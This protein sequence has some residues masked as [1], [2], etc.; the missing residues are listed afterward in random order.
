MELVMEFLPSMD[1]VAG[2]IPPISSGSMK[3]ISQGSNELL[4]SEGIE[5]QGILTPFQVLEWVSCIINP[6]K[7]W[8]LKFY[9][10]LSHK[11]AL[12][13]ALNNGSSR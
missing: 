1:F 5:S 4:I 2:H 12:Y 6:P 8:I 3:H 13:F 11:P 7:C 10:T 9:R